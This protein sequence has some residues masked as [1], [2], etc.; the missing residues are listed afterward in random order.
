MLDQVWKL[1]AVDMKFPRPPAIIQKQD[2]IR[3][4]GIRMEVTI[5]AHARSRQAQRNLSEQ[6]VQFVL[7][8]GRRYR[9]AGALHI[10]LGHRDLPTDKMTY[11]RF[12]HLEG[13]TLVLDDTYAEAVLITAYR[14]RNATKQIRSKRKYERCGLG[15]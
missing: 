12:S 13:T 6:D 2:A 11:Q 8:H 15:R 10:F 7:A 9:C 1:W 4:A 14:N 3:R 5:T